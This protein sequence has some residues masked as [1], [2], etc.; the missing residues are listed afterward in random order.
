MT[1]GNYTL[2]VDEGNNHSGL[3]IKVCLF[4][5]VDHVSVHTEDKIFY[6]QDDFRDFLPLRGWICLREF[7]SYRNIDVMDELCPGVIYCDISR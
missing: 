7:N 4:E 3:M 2:H 5:E 1:L 6:T